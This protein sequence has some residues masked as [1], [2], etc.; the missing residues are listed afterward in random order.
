MAY[1]T[2]WTVTFKDS[3]NNTRV[4]NIQQDGWTGGQTPLTP[5]NNPL[6]WN[7]DDSDNLTKVVRGITG[8]MEVVEHT[9][10]ELA[11]LYPITPLQNRV[12]CNGVFWGYIKAENSTNAWE[13]GPRVIKLNILSP[14]ALSYDIP[15]P[16]NT[17]LGMR[18]MGGAIAEMMSTIGYSYITMAKGDVYNLG[19]FFLGHVRGMLICPYAN[20][21]DYH[22]ANN[23]EI[24]APISIGEFIEYIC[25]RHS[26]IAHDAVDGTSA[27]LVFARLNDSGG[28]YRWTYANIANRNY[29]TAELVRS[30][31]EADHSLM[32]DFSVAGNDHTE[33]LVHPF[34][35]IDITHDGNTGDDRLMA[36]TEQSQYVASNPYNLTPR[37][38]WLTNVNG[39]IKM[40]NITTATSDELNPH[41]TLYFKTS[42]GI[43]ADTLLFSVTFYNVDKSKAYRLKYKYAHNRDTGYDS[44]KISAR[45]KGGWYAY[46]GGGSTPTS[47]SEHKEIF[48]LNGDTSSVTTPSTLYETVTNYVMYVDEYITINFYTSQAGLTNL[49][50]IDIELE[51]KDTHESDYTRWRIQPFVERILGNVGDKPITID[52]KLNDTYFSNFYQ[53]DYTFL[54]NYPVYLLNSQRRLQLTM[55]SSNA[56]N[57]LWYLLTYYITN[58]NETWRIIAITYNV[59]DNNYKVTLH[60]LR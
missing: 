44:L 14:L 60:Q 5:G 9:Y 29:T 12:V 53:T 21:K 35:Y 4:I 6:I 42:S 7:E 47:T 50:M 26:M 51:A 48:S 46:S 20:D 34:S 11:D 52:M 30:A 32:T 49:Y 17:T 39:N 25:T 27:S 57:K 8:R 41:D 10:G 13:S 58:Q 24:F 56:L 15:M 54:T 55:K 22:Y 45:G 31:G 59:R 18:E 43:G 1:V 16:I 36:P 23:D 40:G 37:G 19:E 2:R 28:Y 33:S 38:I 3:D